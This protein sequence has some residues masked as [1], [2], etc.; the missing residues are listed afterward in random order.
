M[1]PG[2]LDRDLL[3]V[4]PESNPAAANGKN[5]VARVDGSPYVKRLDLT[6]GRIRLLSTNERYG[7]MVVDEDAQKFELVGVVVGRSGYPPE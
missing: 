2:F 7:P 1:M 3:F 6:G 4:R 5:A